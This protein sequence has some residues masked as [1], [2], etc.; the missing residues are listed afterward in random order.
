HQL[1]I[2][3]LEA[4]ERGEI[5]RLAVFMPPGSAKSTY[6][7]TIFPAWYLGRHPT[8]SVIAA[9]QT[10]DLAD[11]FGRRC[12]NLVGSQIHRDVFGAGLAP[13][14]RA[15]GHWETEQGGEYHATGVQPFAGRRGDGATLDDLIRGRKDA[16]SKTVRNSVWEWY[17]GD[18]RPRLK[19]N[20]WVVLIM[21]RWHEDDP[22]G[23][24]LPPESI[25]KSG[26]VTAKDGEKWYVLSLA[27]VIETREEEDNDP[28]GRKIGDILW[29]GWFT[30]QMLEQERKTQ[31]KRNWSALYQQKPRPNEGA[32]LK[33]ADWRKWP[34]DKPPK[35]EYVVSV[36]DTAFEEGEENDYTA[37][38]SWGV[39]W[40]EEERPVEIQALQ[41]KLGKP[42]VS[43]RYCCILLERFKD[44]VEF[45]ELRRLAV[46]HYQEWKPDRVLVEKKASGHS[47]IQELRRAKVPVHALKADKSKL[48]RAHAA[49]TVLESGCV[50][51]MDRRWA[52]EVMDECEAFPAGEHD[53]IV[54]TCV[55]AWNWLRKTFHLQLRDEEDEDEVVD[56][57]PRRLYG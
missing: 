20:A 5:K 17:L 55:H 30:P 22:A 10:Q 54:D 37:R 34:K 38:T 7:S 6:A 44:K 29:P 56:P 15:A 46:K 26:W 28:L 27:A 9:S 49:G 24:I 57:T 21:T 4:V 50:F 48:A 18:I 39:F 1:L 40:H 35:C 16:D 13:D 25:G 52:E 42:P 47:L 31:G 2:S 53:D 14:Q 8:Q 41:A 11:R 32:I 51:Y 43:G 36:Y 45:P 33:R 3:K 23:R 12:R 19:P